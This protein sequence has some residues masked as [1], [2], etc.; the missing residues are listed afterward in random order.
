M[1]YKVSDRDMTVDELL[2][3]INNIEVSEAFGTGTVEII[4]P[5]Y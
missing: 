5:V 1:E 2:E 3:H 4:S